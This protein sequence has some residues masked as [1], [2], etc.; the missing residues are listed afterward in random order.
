M[1]ACFTVVGT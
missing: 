1:D